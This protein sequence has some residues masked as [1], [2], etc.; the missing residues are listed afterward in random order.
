M[1][2]VLMPSAVEQSSGQ[3]IG[4]A[5]FRTI[6]RHLNEQTGI[7]LAEVKKGLAVSR[8]SRRLRA[9]RL[10]DFDAYCDV[11][12]G[13]DGAAEMQEMILLLTTNVTRFFREPHHFDSLRSSILPRLVA[14]AKSGGRVR[15]WSAGCSSGEEAY[16]I[17]MCV[18]D[19]FPQAASSNLRILATDIDSN[20]IAKGQKARY[21]IADEDFSEHP[22]LRK[23]TENVP[24][25]DRQFDIADSAK[26]LV[27]FANLNLQ[28]PWP[29]RGKFDVIFCRN[30][31]IYFSM[32]TQQKLW[33]RFC[34]AL[35]DG[36]HLMIGHSERVT[37]SALSILQSAGVT[38]YE[39]QVQGAKK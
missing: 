20:M 35:N 3:T 33:P 18:L 19:M 7:V 38:H 24:G 5:A 29:M 4:D 39:L 28:E 12:S 15:L 6:A 30:V 32:E 14:T 34:S 21:Q 8:L 37:G 23:Y 9:L 1:N 25:M 36:G 16:S 10:P 26:S 17:A 22:I 2:G 13:P 31:V 11:L 27:S